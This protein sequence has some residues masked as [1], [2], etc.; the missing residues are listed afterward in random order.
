MN[1]FNILYDQNLI[2]IKKKCSHVELDWGGGKDTSLTQF[3]IDNERLQKKKY[4]NLRDL[5]EKR[6]KMPVSEQRQ[7][8][9]LQRNCLLIH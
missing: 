1:S 3:T 9:N 5:L 7:L 2:A 4:S 8:T 6:S